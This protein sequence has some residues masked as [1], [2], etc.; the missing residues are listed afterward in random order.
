MR[1]DPTGPE[2]RFAQT[3]HFLQDALRLLESTRHSPALHEVDLISILRML[4]YGPVYSRM[5]QAVLVPVL[6]TVLSCTLRVGMQ[7]LIY[8]SN[9]RYSYFS[10]T[11]LLC[12]DTCTGLCAV[13]LYVRTLA[14]ADLATLATA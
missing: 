6:V 2:M 10:H 5:C 7:L 3:R 1:R 14:T 4:L 12:A 13:N 9:T 8:K 11:R